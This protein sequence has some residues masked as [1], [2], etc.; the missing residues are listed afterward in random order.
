[1]RRG[2][3]PTHTFKTGVD[4][5]DASVLFI[6]YSQ[7]ELPGSKTFVTKVEKTI[8]DCTITENTVSVTLTQAE[9]L[10]FDDC[11]MVFIQI[12][13]G[14]PDDSRIASRIIKSSVDKILKDG[15]I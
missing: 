14:F 8:S 9:T 11:K 2:T 6:T 13:A 4:L 3:T 15:E 5:R 7:E 10:A 1:M 12:R